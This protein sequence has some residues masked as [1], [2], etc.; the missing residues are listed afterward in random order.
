MG[1]TNA[2]ERYTPISRFLGPSESLGKSKR[3]TRRGSY[4]DGV[5]MTTSARE[6]DRFP[7]VTEV[8]CQSAS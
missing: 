1:R 3:N 4:L 2:P 5:D 8:V 6:L 7:A